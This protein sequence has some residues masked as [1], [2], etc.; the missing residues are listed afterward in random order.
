MLELFTN[1]ITMMVGSLLVS[2]PIIIHLINRMRFKRVHWAAIEFLIKA[3][4]RVKRKL[5][6]QQLI[7]LLLRILMVFLISLLLARFLGFSGLGGNESQKTLHLFLLDDTPSM[8]DHWR[9]D[10]ED[11]D[12]FSLGKMLVTEKLGKFIVQAP[13]PQY[14]EVFRLSDLDHPR[15]FDRLNLQSLGEL[16]AWL[17]PL[18]P[19]P[20]RVELKLALQKIKERIADLK[21]TEVVIHLISDFRTKDWSGTG[22]GDLNALFQEL[23]GSGCKV[24]LVD[25]AHPDQGI[26][27]KSPLYHDNLA[28]L[29]LRPETRIAA[30]Y[31]LI[32]FQID[33]ANFSNSERKNIPI[34]FRLNGRERA[35]G[36]VNIPSLKA[37]ETIRVRTSIAPDRLGTPERP[38][39]R[40]N[41]ISVHLE[42]E[43]AG[44]NI[45][46]ARYCVVEVRDKV[47]MLLVEGKSSNL[48][49]DKN[50]FV[51]ANKDAECFF[52][53]KLFA[54]T[55]KGYDV[56]VKT[57][58][59]LEKLNLHDYL[60]IFLCDVGQLSNAALTNLEEYARSGG[61][62]AF[63]MGPDIKQAD[64][65]F[66]NDKLYRKGIGLFPA[67]IEKLPTHADKASDDL[68]VPNR[69]VRRLSGQEQ[70]FVR[71]RDHAAVESLYSDGNKTATNDSR[72]YDRILQFV[73]IDRYFPVNRLLWK[74]DPNYGAA[75]QEIMTL[76][77]LKPMSTYTALVRNFLEKIPIN[78]DQYNEYRD[79]LNGYINQIKTIADSNEPL[80]TLSKKWSDM[81]TDPG[82]KAKNRPSLQ[83]FWQKLELAELYRE[84]LRILD[85]I[86][87]GDPLYVSKSFGKGRVI[88]GFSSA[89]SSWNDLEGLSASHFPPL[90][91]SFQR[92]LASASSDLN[93]SIGTPYRFELPSKNYSPKV[94]SYL[95]EEQE[96]RTP[97]A[98]NSATAVLNPR[99]E[100]TM[101]S[102]VIVP[103]VIKPITTEDKNNT[104]NSP[105]SPKPSTPNNP[106]GMPS[107]E[108]LDKR[109]VFVLNFL[110]GNQQGCYLFE[111]TE[112][113]AAAVPGGDVKPVPDFRTIS[114]NIN[115][116]LEGDLKRADRDDI[117]QLAGKQVQLV[118]PSSIDNLEDELKQRKHDLSESPWFYL[119]LLLILLAEQFMAVK[120]SFH[121]H[122]HDPVKP[123]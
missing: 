84:A 70:I 100:E 116:I 42:N 15:S 16:K 71:N 96:N 82:D 7:L 59:D 45:D 88:A 46:N 56:Q 19:S 18:K 58:A 90:L 23:Q 6:I 8:G 105:L 1:P 68:I 108:E 98:A 76:P 22:E 69:W 48:K 61:G 17:S 51:P 122:S 94:K 25:V 14:A 49:L 11:H 33:V 120:L 53:Y 54:D 5:L 31:Q 80:Y 29:D 102:E 117:R 86:K 44:L 65:V 35:E 83:V 55:I 91:M 72:G 95:L 93:L 97:G 3:Q 21:N 2:V 50:R 26:D 43:Q 38:L 113:R 77:N 40:F 34:T 110:D 87:Y 20:L 28:I 9:E 106:S 89:G 57:P 79:V 115:A 39:D 10:G 63:F 37:N 52:I 64:A 121:T 92:Y 109:N 67:P 78:E 104:P 123:I 62:V 107:A 99:G 36:M 112:N 60:T 4:K 12:S 27:Q 32:E 114:Y 66:Y 81:L 111:F 47:P 41:L 13:T 24:I 118:S 85:T 75:T 30:Q 74:D 73:V 103:Q 119:I 101:V